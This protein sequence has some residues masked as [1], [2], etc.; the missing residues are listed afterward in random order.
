M[1]FPNS[2]LLN[3]QSRKEFGILL[4]LD[5]LMRYDI[6]II[7][8]SN[9]EE[10]ILKFKGIVEE[11]N[12]GFFR[13]EEQ[14]EELN[15]QKVELSQAQDALSQIEKEMYENEKFRV[16][17]ALVEKDQEKLEPLLKFMEERRILTVGDDNYYRTSEKGQEFY[18]Q[19]VDQLESYLMYFE[20]FAYVDLENGI[21][22]DPNEDLLEGN[23][24]TDLRV[25]IAEF[26]GIDPFRVVF[27]AMMSED[28]FF[29]NPDWKFE[30]GLGT[31]FDE[32][33]QIVQDQVAVNDLSYEDDMG[34]VN[35]EDVIR[36]ILKQGESL[37]K[38]RIKSEV[39][40]GKNFGNDFL[41]EEQVLAKKYSW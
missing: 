4:L 41:G 30:L 9:L 5:H 15:F 8:R 16:N 27:L 14:E 40:E 13:S 18:S 19:L 3:I 33:E 2:R 38:K 36:D 23:Q 29:E 6:L 12:K 39:G 35:G 10:K 28:K 24:W 17:I 34:I 25:A 20:I 21:F 37:A 7:E 31:L 11:L 1:N 22:G 32:L 26:K